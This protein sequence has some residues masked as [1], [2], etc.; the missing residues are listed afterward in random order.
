MKKILSLLVIV[1]VLISAQACSQPL[2]NDSSVP[3]DSSGASVFASHHSTY[4]MDIQ[5]A[6]I[7]DIPSASANGG[8][9]FVSYH[10]QAE[11]ENRTGEMTLTHVGNDRRQRKCVSGKFVCCF[12]PE[13]GGPGSVSVC[14]G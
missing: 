7:A 8:E 4:Q 2:R 12:Q 6:G 5:A 13:W 14:R 11:G 1:W 9:L 10:Y 3:Q